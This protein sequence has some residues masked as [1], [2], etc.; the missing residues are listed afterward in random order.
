MNLRK[1]LFWLHLSAGVFA[2]VVVFIMSVTGVLLTYEK[3]MLAWADLRHF[4]SA[5]SPSAQRVPIDLLLAKVRDEKGTLPATVT[6]RSHPSDPVAFVFG[7]E[8]TVYANPYTGELLGEGSAGLR[9]FFRVVTD[10]HRWLGAGTEGRATGKAITGACNLA[11]LFIVCSGLYLWWPRNW[12]WANVRNVI[13]FRGGLSGKA[14]DFNWHNTIGFWCCVPLFFIVLGAT[15][16]S[17]PWA[18]NLVY[19][20]VGE[21]PPVRRGPGPGGPGG[22]SEPGSRRGSEGGQKR[23]EGNRN[24]ETGP[25]PEAP[26][27][28]AQP[29]AAGA[30]VL[31]TG[32]LLAE[33]APAAGQRGEDSREAQSGE[34]R[35]REGPGREGRRGQGPNGRGPGGAA[36]VPADLNLE[37]FEKLLTRA[38]QHVAGWKT[39]SLRLPAS[40]DAP[41][42]F[43]IDQGMGGQPQLRSTLTL[44]RQTAEVATWETFS[45]GS[46]GQQLRS[47]LRFIHTGEVGGFAGQTIAGIASLGACFLVWT[48]LA[49]TWRRFRAWIGRR[50]TQKGIPA[51]SEVA[52]PKDAEARGS[53][54]A[55]SQSR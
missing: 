42:S 7:R 48:G 55:A 16:I 28:G 17:Y 38:E 26:A 31:Q 49:L 21:E 34:D 1:I 2:G 43:L 19:R 40:N 53:R 25:E 13:L 18:S 33:A 20:A 9:S 23:R 3:Q 27:A 52:A 12:R 54:V 6:L 37:G 47:F 30:E 41:V 51:A 22:A 15:V 24:R 8:S 39:I 32:Q 4:R 44:D 10:W 29:K 14:R 36:E 35:R 46:R 5:P 50:G 45:D 11:F